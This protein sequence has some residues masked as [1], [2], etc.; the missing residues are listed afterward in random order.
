MGRRGPAYAAISSEL[1]ALLG[2][3]GAL[4]E[5]TLMGCEDLLRVTGADQQSDDG[6]GQVLQESDASR[7][8]GVRDRGVGL[9][10]LGAVSL[11]FIIAHLDV[12]AGVSGRIL[13]FALAETLRHCVG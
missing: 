9:D 1:G 3:V 4:L 13:Q 11:G 10:K 5:Q 8:R 6:A 7:N 12:G 2:K